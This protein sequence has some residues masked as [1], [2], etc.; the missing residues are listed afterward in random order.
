MAQG[1]DSSLATWS[2]SQC[3]FAIEYV[4]RVLDEIRLIVIDAFFSLPRGGAEIGGLLLGQFAAGRLTVAG[5]RPVE[6][7]HAFGPSFT[8]SE[9]DCAALQ[10]ALAACASQPFD[11]QPIGWY[12]SHTRSEIFLSEADREIHNRYFPKPWQVALVLRPHTFQPTRAGFFFRE[13]GGRIHADNSYREFEITPLPAGSVAPPPPVVPAPPP[14]P[15]V[16]RQPRPYPEPRRPGAF[17][18]V[19][20]EPPEELRPEPPP[21][22]A[23]VAWKPKP[24][25][26]AA[27]PPPASLLLPPPVPA[28][29][30][31]AANGADSAASAAPPPTAAAP[32]APAEVPAEP[33]APAPAV[34][35]LEEAPPSTALSET[36]VPDDIALA[37]DDGPTA[38][39]RFLAVEMPAPKRRRRALTIFVIA[40][41]LGACG[42][43][44]RGFWWTMATS[45]VHSILPAGRPPSLGLRVLD[46]NGQLQIQWDAALPAIRDAKAARLT[47]NDGPKQRAIPLD[48]AHLHSGAFTYARET[49]RVEVALA[50]TPPGGE[51]IREQT[52]FLGRLPPATAD[53]ASAAQL[54]DLQRQNQQLK[55]DLDKERIRSRKLE[56]E[57]QYLRDQR[58]RELRQKRQERQQIDKLPQ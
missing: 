29:P 10:E 38:L 34:P 13:S 6:C 52:T 25:E 1:T 12:H 7:E 23:P 41:L 3:P 36:R 50:I 46:A 19:I 8:L 14:P 35:V 30:P 17:L 4:P 22:A 33:P 27:P 20:A 44:T 42:Y 39:P 40:A 16:E 11:R 43:L 18:N 28:L 15:P 32:P 5:Y 54:D 31:A 45:A 9:R 51:P 57:A 53:P 21:P 56:R 58:E 49:A 24:P 47:I 2:A 37:A 26:P 55:S 48:L